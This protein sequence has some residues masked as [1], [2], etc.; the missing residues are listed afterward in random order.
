MKSRFFASSDI[1]G[2][3]HE[4]SGQA[5]SQRCH[6]LDFFVF[7]FRMI[8][9][10]VFLLFGREESKGG[11]LDG[12]CM[13]LHLC[14]SLLLFSPA[15]LVPKESRRRAEKGSTTTKGSQSPRERGIGN[16][17]TCYL[18]SQRKRL[19]FSLSLCLQRCIC[20]S[21]KCMTLPLLHR[22]PLGMSQSETFLC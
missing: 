2:S 10:S 19:S 5:L 13:V 12:L 6:A 11:G 4:E 22:L 16:V 8:R 7:F 17:V 18:T 15:V 9:E 1:Q 21:I 3:L 14:Q 20:L